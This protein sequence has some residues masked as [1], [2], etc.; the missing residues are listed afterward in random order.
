M[1]MKAMII[2][3]VKQN[4]DCSSNEILYG[5]SEKRSIATI[6]RILSKLIK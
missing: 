2:E 1:D 3:F 4:P 6:K 5:I